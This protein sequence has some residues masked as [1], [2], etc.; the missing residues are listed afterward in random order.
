MLL[1]DFWRGMQEYLSIQPSPRGIIPARQHAWVKVHPIRRLDIDKRQRVAAVIH[2]KGFVKEL[3]IGVRCA[4]IPEQAAP[5][6]A[7]PREVRAAPGCAGNGAGCKTVPIGGL[8]LLSVLD[9][10]GKVNARQPCG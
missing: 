1:E 6:L 10:A 4:F 2:V 3:L 7:V 5:Q 8:R 9:D